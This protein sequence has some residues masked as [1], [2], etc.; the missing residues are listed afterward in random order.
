MNEGSEDKRRI[1][2]AM[3]E[4]CIEAAK[5]GYERAAISGLCAEGALEAALSAIQ[6]VDVDAV[7][8][9]VGKPLP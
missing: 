3:R 9:K 4:A 5:D 7:V 6:M 1:A 8:R 2:V